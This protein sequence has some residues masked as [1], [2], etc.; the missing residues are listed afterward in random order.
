M[1]DVKK[2]FDKYDNLEKVIYNNKINDEEQILIELKN[3][4]NEISQCKELVNKSKSLMIKINKSKNLL[5]IKHKLEK[6]INTH[7]DLLN[8]HQLEI[9]YLIIDQYKSFL[10]I[11]YDELNFKIENIILNV[12][13]FNYLDFYSM[14]NFKK[15]KKNNLEKLI[16]ACNN[17]ISLYE[18]PKTIFLEHLEIVDT[19]KSILQFLKKFHFE[20]K[21]NKIKQL[22]RGFLFEMKK[23]NQS[24]IIK[25]QPNKSF[26]EIIMNKYLSKYNH[27]KQYILYPDYIFMNKNNS[28][29]YIMP[30]YNSDLFHYLKKKTTP[31][32]DK[33]M[34]KII[35]FLIQIIYQLH[36]INIIYGDVKLENIIL[37]YSGDKIN[38]IKLIDFD[39][40]LFDEIPNEF[41]YFDEKILALFE[42]KKPRGTKLYMSSNNKMN[43][44][45]DIYSIGVFIIIF[46]YKNIMK[47]LQENEEN[48]TESLK[49]KIHNKLVFYKN[50]M[51]DDVYKIKLMKYMFR[52]LND[53]RFH[54]YWNHEISMKKIYLNVKKCIHQDINSYELYHD[55]V[56]SVI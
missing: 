48:I 45:N 26:S 36:N 52:I 51:E 14:I 5:K 3:D 17:K 28:Y 18:T 24:F 30:K 15:K 19:Q 12:D 8:Y 4:L 35:Q 33:T 9:L 29:F 22:K 47:I 38:D 7:I 37:K 13:Y 6:S 31:L 25:Y 21:S 2:Y 1:N 56:K 20:F 40:S 32:K 10:N 50:K 34:I 42:N 16:Y 55:F 23:N 39:V 44:S 54:H 41:N 49:M 53:K 11:E 46:F 43:K 27:L